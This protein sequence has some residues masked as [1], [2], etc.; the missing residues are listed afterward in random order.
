MLK[1]LI[2]GP[3]PEDPVPHSHGG[4]D[5]AAQ[6]NHLR[7]L[8]CSKTFHPPHPLISLSG[9][10]GSGGLW[11]GLTGRLLPPVRRQAALRTEGN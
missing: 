9:K 7:W 2:Q 8:Q 3:R 6:R 1:L 5:V 11:G 10:L 4:S